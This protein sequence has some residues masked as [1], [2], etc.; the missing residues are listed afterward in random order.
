MLT[1]NTSAARRGPRDSRRFFFFSFGAGGLFPGV[2][3]F[4]D[5]FA[6]IPYLAERLPERPPDLRQPARPED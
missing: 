1:P 2:K 6:D 5:F 4:G 3:V